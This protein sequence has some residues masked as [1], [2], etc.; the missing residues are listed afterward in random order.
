LGYRYKPIFLAGIPVSA[1][2]HYLPNAISSRAEGALA[3]HSRV[4]EPG[5]LRLLYVGSVSQYKLFDGLKAILHSSAIENAL[6]ELGVRIEIVIAGDCHGRSAAEEFHRIRSNVNGRIKLTYLGA[7]Y[8]LEAKSR[9]FTWADC[10]LMPT[11]H[12]T[13]GLPVTLLEALC[14]GLPIISSDMGL[15]GEAVDKENGWLVPPADS[16]ALEA[17]IL[18]LLR[19]WYYSGLSV[20]SAASQALYAKHFS[21]EAFKAGVRE[22]M[23]LGNAGADRKVRTK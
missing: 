1:G 22:L 11:T 7:V 21:R 14:A 8:D 2:I 13:E 6:A 16:E 10:F 19:R 17:S 18:D 5:L 9:L 15:C 12:P 3:E 23:L 20:E 4:R